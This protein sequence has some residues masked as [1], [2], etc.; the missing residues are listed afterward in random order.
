MEAY[1]FSDIALQIVATSERKKP[2]LPTGAPSVKAMRDMRYHLYLLNRH[3]HISDKKLELLLAIADNNME[4]CQLIGFDH[5][6]D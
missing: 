3:G 4:L 5:I 2:V 6:C 1:K